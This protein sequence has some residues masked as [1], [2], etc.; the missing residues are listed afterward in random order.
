MALQWT[1]LLM[2]GSIMLAFSTCLVLL[3]YSTQSK[4]LDDPS[5][6]PNLVANT[7]TNGNTEQFIIKDHQKDKPPRPHIV[8]VLADD[9]GYNDIGYHAVHGMSAVRT[10]HLDT[11][12]S[13]GVKLENYYVQPICSPSR[14]VLMTGRY[15]IRY[16]LQHR[17]FKA[18]Q[19]TCLP[20]S[21]TTLPEKLK[22]LGYMTHAIGKWHLGY[23]RTECLPTR[24][25]FDSFFGYAVGGTDHYVHNR[26]YIFKSNPLGASYSVNASY[27][28]STTDNN[29]NTV[30]DDLE[31]VGPAKYAG[32]KDNGIREYWSGKDLWENETVTWEHK[33]VY[34]TT[35]FTGKAQ[36]TIEK[37]DSKKPLFLYLAYKNVHRPL[38]APQRYK[39]MFKDIKNI[40]RRLMAAM[41]YI[42]DEGVKNVTDTLKKTGMWNDTVLIFSSDNGGML[43]VDAAGNNW[44]LKGG[45][46]SL[47]EGGIR[48]VGFVNSPLL[49]KH[50]KGTVNKEL[51]HISDW[52]PTLVDGVA[53]GSTA[54]MKKPLDGI[55]QWKM[56]SEGNISSR[57]EILLNIDE[58]ED[59]PQMVTSEY[60]YWQANMDRKE[61][62][63]PLIR[64]GIRSG[65][66]KLLTG[67]N[68]RSAIWLPPPESGMGKQALRDTSPE[69]FQRQSVVRLFNIKSDPTETCNLARNSKYLPI[70]KEL[71]K[72]LRK[73]ANQAVP[74]YYPSEDP[75]AN[76]ALR[77]GAWT[78]WLDNDL[79][80]FSKIYPLTF[81]PYM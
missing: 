69:C 29:L 36:E 21:E 14:S 28:N 64:A 23:C 77:G 79:E 9:L 20:L 3:R 66:W 74:A 39:D 46:W 16:G 30:I 37:H 62:L 58:L 47:Y 55:N 67:A 35:L 76:P 32:N 73:Y 42:M 65:D 56:I 41:A 2:F 49:S 33:G 80:T 4:S 63:N 70:V 59:F 1:T 40:D 72:K 48:A 18:P 51:M 15:L 27:I 57:S 71:S 19:P 53:G 7:D 25:G 10:P 75:M 68:I 31:D 6:E 38:Q 61:T 26:T 50:V 8:F 24:R 52:F 34:S 11:L 17:L 43:K 22:E 44:P 81:Q 78:P 54:Q 12:A 5:H 13:E 60:D 45:K